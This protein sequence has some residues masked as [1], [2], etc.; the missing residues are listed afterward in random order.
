MENNDPSTPSTAD[1][2]RAISL[3]YKHATVAA[4]LRKKA[5]SL[6]KTGSNA[7]KSM[8]PLFETGTQAHQVMAAAYLVIGGRA[9]DHNAHINL[10]LDWLGREPNDNPNRP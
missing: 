8:L 2:Y 3:A 5:K 4:E 9:E 10:G 6:A 7:E 1:E